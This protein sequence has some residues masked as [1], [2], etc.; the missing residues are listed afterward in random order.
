MFGKWMQKL[1]EKL[2]RIKDDDSGSAFAFVVIGVTALMIIGATVL[3]LAT[4]YVVDRK[5]VV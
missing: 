3:S 2:N 1:K 5:S 4:N